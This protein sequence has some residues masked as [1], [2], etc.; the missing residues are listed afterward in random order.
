MGQILE[1]AGIVSKQDFDAA[2]SDRTLLITA[3]INADNFEGYLYP[4]TYSFTR[5][6]TPRNTAKSVIFAMLKNGEDRWRSEFD[7]RADQLGLSRHEVLTIA[8]IIENETDNPE[9][10]PQISSV[11][12]N[13]LKQNMKLESDAT[14][15]YGISDFEGTIYDITDVDRASLHQY[16]TYQRTGLPPGPIDNPSVDA[17]RATLYPAETKYI[18]MRRTSTGLLTFAEE[19][20]LYKPS[21]QPEQSKEQPKE[22]AKKPAGVSLKELLKK[23]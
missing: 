22:P 21:E 2:V 6:D 8:S 16:N 12:H 18:F 19:A 7:A 13:R 14:V 10:Y 17:I 1:K 15:L 11:I 20:R 23:K 9:Y 4:D 3:G 5:L